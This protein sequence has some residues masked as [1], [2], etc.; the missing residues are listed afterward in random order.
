MEPNE[1]TE[2]LDRFERDQ[3]IQNEQIGELTKNV[4]ALAATVGTVVEQQRNLFGRANRPFQWGAFVSAL[5]GVGV[6]AGLL[7]APLQKEMEGQHRFDIQV[8]QH[9]EEDAYKMG[10]LETEVKWLKTMEDRLNQ[11]IHG[12]IIK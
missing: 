6:F 5:V 4:S 7:I 2:W 8:M 10:K 11:R 1:F 12:S 9:L 3:E